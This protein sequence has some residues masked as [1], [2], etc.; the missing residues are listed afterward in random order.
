M[1]YNGTYSEELAS[2]AVTS[3]AKPCFSGLDSPSDHCGSHRFKPPPLLSPSASESLLNWTDPWAW[4]ESIFLVETDVS[5]LHSPTP[6]Y[7]RKLHHPLL[8]LP[9]ECAADDGRKKTRG[10][11]FQSIRRFL[12]MATLGSLHSW[13][14]LLQC[15][16]PHHH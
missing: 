7:C 13:C 15:R 1:P 8:T 4:I 2:R 3:C 12:S 16:M 9:I 14:W 6:L 5:R 11:I 10:F